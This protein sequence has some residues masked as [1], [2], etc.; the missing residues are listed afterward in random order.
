MKY[1]I[2]KNRAI[3]PKHCWTRISDHR[4]RKNES[5]LSREKNRSGSVSA[6]KFALYGL[7]KKMADAQHQKLCYLEA[8][9]FESF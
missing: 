4:D 7:A 3:S 6:A 8:H 1:E 5:A 2:N 9:G